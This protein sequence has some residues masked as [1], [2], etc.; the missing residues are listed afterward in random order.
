MIIIIIVIL[1]I[2]YK[3]V[4][5]RQNRRINAATNTMTATVAFRREPQP[6]VHFATAPKPETTFQG[7]YQGTRNTGQVSGS[8]PMPVDGLVYPNPAPY[9]EQFDAPP[10]YDAVLAASPGGPPLAWSSPTA[11]YHQPAMDSAR[12]VGQMQ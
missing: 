11:V 6:Q 8:Y 12:D 3:I 1:L 7:P 5:P 9:S 10:S 2:A 4:R